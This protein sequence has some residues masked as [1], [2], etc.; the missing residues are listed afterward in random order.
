MINK[1]VHEYVYDNVASTW[2]SYYNGDSIKEC[3]TKYT[4]EK[5]TVN[6]NDLFKIIEKYENMLME[7]RKYISEAE[8]MREDLKEID[9][10]Y[11]KKIDSINEKIGNITVSVANIEGKYSIMDIIMSDTKESLKS[12]NK[13]ASE[14]TEMRGKIDVLSVKISHVEDSTKW[15]KQFLLAPIATG[16]VIIA[17]KWIFGF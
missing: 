14:I 3:S 5:I 4:S 8:A 15:W 2:E 16:V 17:V 6:I 10:K 9:D 1:P 12:I 13:L 11:D 7:M